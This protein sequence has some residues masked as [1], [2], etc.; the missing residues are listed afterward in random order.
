MSTTERPKYKPELAGI[1]NIFSSR[2]NTVS[3][4][5]KVKASKQIYSSN[6]TCL[7]LSGDKTKLCSSGR[8]VICPDF[9]W[10]TV[11]LLELLGAMSAAFYS[12]FHLT[13][14]CSI[15][16]GRRLLQTPGTCRTK[17]DNKGEQQSS[18]PP[19]SFKEPI[20]KADLQ[21]RQERSRFSF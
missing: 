20:T 13:H 1:L 15:S 2:G 11:Q 8:L 17:C 9:S 5:I 16:C 10:A 7:N 6:F 3:L 14:L 21:W 19:V 12:A 4:C 18:N